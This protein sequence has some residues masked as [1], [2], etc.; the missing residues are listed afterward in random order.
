MH[1][2]PAVRPRSGLWGFA[3]GCAAGAFMVFLTVNF[4]L[5]WILYITTALVGVV[6]LPR[7]AVAFGG[8]D[9]LALRLFVLGLILEVD[10]WVIHQDYVYPGG[11]NGISVNLMVLA[12]AFWVL[13]WIPARRAGL[14]AAW[15]LDPGLRR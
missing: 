2:V 4:S 3:L 10:W 9:G 6:L 12:G 7:V 13:M 14:A 11:V 15:K 5:N 8:L 1:G